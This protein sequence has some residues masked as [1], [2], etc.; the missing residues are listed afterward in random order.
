MKNL[1]IRI[2]ALGQLGGHQRQIARH[3]RVLGRSGD[4]GQEC[5]R[6]ERRLNINDE[7]IRPGESGTQ[8]DKSPCNMVS[9]KRENPIP[10]ARKRGIG[11]L[12][13]SDDRFDG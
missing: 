2:E 8:H 11:R 10:R 12:D 3:I 6:I 1:I 7:R 13:G 4:G 9:G 5:S